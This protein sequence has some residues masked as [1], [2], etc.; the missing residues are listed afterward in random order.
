MTG[1]FP[2]ESLATFNRNDWQ[3]SSEIR[4]RALKAALAAGDGLPEGVER[5][6]DRS[7]ISIM[8]LRKRIFSP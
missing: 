8:E 1:K 5:V 4:T 6:E 2:P 7:R 3:V